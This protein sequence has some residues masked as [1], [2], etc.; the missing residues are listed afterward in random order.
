M[1]KKKRKRKEKHKKKKEKEEEEEEEKKKKTYSAQE[2][3]TCTRKAT[4]SH[5]T[6]MQNQ[7]IR[8]QLSPC[9]H[10]WAS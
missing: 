8:H 1:R 9:K 3:P 5:T 7:Q 4:L 10:T 6:N 2:P